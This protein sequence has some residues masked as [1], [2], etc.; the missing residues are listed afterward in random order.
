MILQSMRFSITC[1]VYDILKASYIEAQISNSFHQNKFVFLFHLLWTS[2]MILSHLFLP[3]E[4]LSLPA[5]SHPIVQT[6]WW[7]D[8]HVMSSFTRL[9]LC[10]A[11]PCLRPF[12]SSH[13]T[14]YPCPALSLSFPYKLPKRVSNCFA[15]LLPPTP[16]SLLKP[17]WQWLV[18]D[19]P[20]WQSSNLF[21]DLSS[22]D[23]LAKSHAVGISPSQSALPFPSVWL[24]IKFPLTTP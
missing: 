18:S 8:T 17:T 24:P 3:M 16:T 9:G 20:L 13:F 21:S 5:T 7:H 23:H 6:A 19:F 12:L 4:W 2:D 15:S 1:T 22:F 10:A 14:Y 11:Q